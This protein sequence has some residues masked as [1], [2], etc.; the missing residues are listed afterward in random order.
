MLRFAFAILAG[1]LADCS[2]DSGTPD[3]D[4]VEADSGVL[5]LSCP[6]GSVEISGSCRLPCLEG[7]ERHEDGNCRP[8]CPEGWI[9]VDGGCAP[10]CPDGMEQVGA[11]CRP[12][13]SSVGPAP[14]LQGQQFDTSG[15]QDG[16]EV[17]YVD[18]AKGTSDGPGLDPAGAF[19]TLEQALLSLP[20]GTGA[21]SIVIAEGEYDVEDLPW[22]GGQAGTLRLLGVCSD[23][24]TFKGGELTVDGGAFAL[25]LARVRLVPGGILVLDAEGLTVSDCVFDKQG[26]NSSDI[27]NWS[28]TTPGH[29]AIVRSR[30]FGGTAG[31]SLAALVGVADIRQNRF[32]GQTLNGIAVSSYDSLVVASNVFVE[33]VQ[34]AGGVTAIRVW[35]VQSPGSQLTVESNWIGPGF[36]FGISLTALAGSVLVEGNSLQGCGVL[37]L[38]AQHMLG[39]G[40]DPRGKPASLQLVGDRMVGMDSKPHQELAGI[41]LS[42]AGDVKVAG[43][44]ILALEGEGLSMSG[45]GRVHI[46]GT[47]IEGSL[48][49]GILADLSE[50]G[51]IEV[52]KSLIVGSA[53]RGIAA[54]GVGTVHVA[55]SVVA[56]SG[57][58]GISLRGVG[59]AEMARNTISDNG[60]TGI[61]MTSLAG[62][63]DAVYEVRSNACRDNVGLGILLRSAGKG[64]V[65]LEGNLASGTRPG[66]V[67]NAQTKDFLV[68]DGIAVL[69]GTD[70]VASHAVLTGTSVVTSNARLGVYAF[71]EGTSLSVEGE[72]SFDDTNGYGGIL[73]EAPPGASWN[74]VKKGGAEVIGAEA[75]EPEVDVPAPDS[76]NLGGGGDPRG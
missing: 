42:D 67:S 70:G 30:F 22:L 41:F 63:E 31:L 61:E 29:V 45:E 6:E 76:V 55:D 72:L 3:E 24:V 43:S 28:A 2:G 66:M 69:T 62:S 49:D 44:T 17:R 8:P 12:P 27:V 60:S 65:T 47:Y 57:M 68:G 52:E 25:E 64:L 38:K 18:A 32:S 10:P 21:A 48:R 74:V 16:D 26:K 14:C 56:A 7:W 39:T 71:G 19:A 53:A 51:E 50:A 36:A 59:G 40:G 37:Y 33:P 5:P 46:E 75:V 11:L 9:E 20:E 15:V 34:A 1:S 35:Q 23:L 58:H 54:K 13:D 73:G 4:A